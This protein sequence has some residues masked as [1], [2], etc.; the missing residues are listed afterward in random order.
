MLFSDWA[1]KDL[2]ITPRPKAINFGMPKIRATALKY[3]GGTSDQFVPT[4]KEATKKVGNSL[5]QRFGNVFYDLLDRFV[6]TAKRTK[7]F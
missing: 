3:F 7:G 4:T 2:K 6:K 1:M 5:K